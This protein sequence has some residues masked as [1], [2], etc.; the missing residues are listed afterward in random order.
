MIM[1]TKTTQALRQLRIEVQRVC[2]E[3][4]D[5]GLRRALEGL[6]DLF[7]NVWRDVFRDDVVAV[8]ITQQSDGSVSLHSWMTGLR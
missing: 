5:E 7:G 8:R 2:R 6:S 4:D 1:N 3:I